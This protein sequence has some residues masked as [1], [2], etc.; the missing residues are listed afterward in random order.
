VTDAQG[1]GGVAASARVDKGVS[2]NEV[3]PLVLTM[4]DT[5]HHRAAGDKR[6]DV[7]SPFGKVLGACRQWIALQGT[8]NNAWRRLEGAAWSG[9]H[10]DVR[11]TIDTIIALKVFPRCATS[12]VRRGDDR[13]Q[14]ASR[15]QGRRTTCKISS[16]RLALVSSL[17]QKQARQR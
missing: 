15:G 8:I 10:Q 3:R 5:S 13:Q 17:N 12:R 16:S 2:G 1:H 7:G 11:I 6:G 9:T 14:A 4:I